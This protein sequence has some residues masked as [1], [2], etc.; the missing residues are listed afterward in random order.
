MIE[1][2]QT[3]KISKY[4]NKNPLECLAFE[5]RS[6]PDVHENTIES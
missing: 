2:I 6:H 5:K 3:A 1:E 4:V